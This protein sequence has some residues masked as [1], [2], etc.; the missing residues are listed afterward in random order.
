MIRP[1][2]NSEA[3]D[4][5]GSKRTRL[6][7]RRDTS[8]R[9]RRKPASQSV[10]LS[11]RWSRAGRTPRRTSRAS[12][13]RSRRRGATRARHRPWRSSSH[14]RS[15]RERRHRTSPR[16]V[17]PSRQDTRRHT[18]TWLRACSDAR[19]P[20]RRRLRRTPAER[21]CG[22]QRTSSLFVDVAKENG[23]PR[24]PWPMTYRAKFR[25]VFRSL[26]APFARA[27]VPREAQQHARRVAPSS[28]KTHRCVSSPRSCS[29]ERVT[30][31]DLPDFKRALFVGTS[32]V[33]RF[34]TSRFLSARRARN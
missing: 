29:T 4:A 17:G 9:T 5:L 2:R 22:V 26:R 25:K 31:R 11:S 10:R 34:Q 28:T 8:A 12:G 6:A 13:A 14:R 19:T 7:R 30:P 18:G 24:S 27:R 20:W 33:P 3:R 16:P 23:T 15:R 32:S 1:R 21:A